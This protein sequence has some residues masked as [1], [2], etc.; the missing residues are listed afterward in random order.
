IPR[1][2]GGETA[3]D[4]LAFACQGCN[5]HKYIKTEARDPVSD[6]IVLLYHPRQQRWHDHFAWSDDFT[7][8]VGL[9]PTGRATS[10]TL[11]L[12]REELINLRRVLY[13]M[14]EH[15]PAEMD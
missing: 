15:P 7:L 9:T 6:S 12:N 13:A 11:H 1:H 10:Q 5:S 2:S 14:G 3:L 4:N 8:I